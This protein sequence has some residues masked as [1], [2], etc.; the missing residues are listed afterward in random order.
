[1]RASM[2]RSLQLLALMG[3]HGGVR[4]VMVMCIERCTHDIA[5]RMLPM[6]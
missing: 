1:M 2:R 3:V 6:M 4:R 5:S